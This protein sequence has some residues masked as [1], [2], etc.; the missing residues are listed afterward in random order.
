[1][2]EW[3]PMSRYDSES[4]FLLMLDMLLRNFRF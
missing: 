1:M 4:D 2:I 3:Y